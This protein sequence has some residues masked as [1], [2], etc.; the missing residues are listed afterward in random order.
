MKRVAIRVENTDDDIFV[1]TS[2]DLGSGG[3]KNGQT[4]VGPERDSGGRGKFLH[5]HPSNRS[6]AMHAFFGVAN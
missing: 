5:Y 2:S 1:A 6:P 3:V 4:A